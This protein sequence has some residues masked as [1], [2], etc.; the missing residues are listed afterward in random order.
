MAATKLN[1]SHHRH[2]RTLA[3]ILKRIKL[4]GATL[5]LLTPKRNGREASQ[6]TLDIVSDGAP[7]ATGEKR[8]RV[9][10]LHFDDQET[11]TTPSNG[12]HAAYAAYRVAVQ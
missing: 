1:D 11:L 10:T 4:Q 9:A 3:L 7:A 5:H 6:F 2:L 8:G 12:P